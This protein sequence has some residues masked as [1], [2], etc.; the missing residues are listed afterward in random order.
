MSAI[1]TVKVKRDG[2]KGYH[3][4]NATDFDPKKHEL[5]EPESD[6]KPAGKTGRKSKAEAEQAAE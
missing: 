5:A 4:I 6:H 1:Q 2:P 3:L